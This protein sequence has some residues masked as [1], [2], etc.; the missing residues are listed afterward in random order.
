MIDI[1]LIR[2][3]LYQVARH[4]AKRGLEVNVDVLLNLELR[5][6]KVQMTYE[7]LQAE[8]NTYSK[9]IGYFKKNGEDA[10]ELIKN[11]ENLGANIEQTKQELNAIQ[12]EL[13]YILHNLPN[14]PHN[15]VPVGSN[16]NDNVEVRK[17]AEPNTFDFAVKDH[18]EL[19]NLQGGIDFARAAKMSG[20]RFV[21]LRDK[22]A[23]LHRALAQFMLDLH[24]QKHGYQEFYTP[25]LVHAKTLFGTGQLPKFADDLFCIKQDESSDFYLIPTA[26]VSLTS[27]FS[28]EIINENDLPIKMVAHSPCFRSEAGA[29]GRDTKGMIRQ[30][31]FDKVELVQLVHPDNSMIALEELTANAE[32]VLQALELPY[33]VIELCTGDLGFSA[34]KTYDL[35][36]WI[37]SQNQYREISSCSNCGDFQTRRMQARFRSNITGKPELMHSL[38]GSGVAV[39]RALVAVIENYQQEDGSIKIPDVLQKYMNGVKKI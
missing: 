1:N 30:H 24:T 26:E 36:V 9:K 8:R 32:T 22:F 3:N 39:G 5:R 6:K 29:A 38:N 7:T 37:P 2:S 21:I 13:E 34:C 11:V 25:Y 23:C 19:G 33:R 10:S 12:T 35:E 16:E 20:A 27:V 31:Q 4:L 15:T 17:W 28:G 14:L 18:V